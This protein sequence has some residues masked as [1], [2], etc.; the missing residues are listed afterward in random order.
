MIQGSHPSF[1]MRK[2]KVPV[3]VFHLPSRKR[4]I[5]TPWSPSPRNKSVPFN[6]QN[7]HARALMLNAVAVTSQRDG[8]LRHL[9]VLLRRAVGTAD[10][11]LLRLR[12]VRHLLL[13]AEDLFVLDDWERRQHL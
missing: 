8:W 13:V 9:E 3:P 2:V 6:S 7:F 12:H 11:L 10:D 4:L 1:I 5:K